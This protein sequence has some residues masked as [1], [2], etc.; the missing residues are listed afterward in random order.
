MLWT[1]LAVYFLRRERPLWSAAA[2]AA[3]ALTREQLVFVLPLLVLPWLARR[4][5]GAVALFLSVA[6]GP[7]VIWQAVLRVIFGHWGLE[8]SFATTRGLHLPLAG[9]WAQRSQP[10]FGDMIVFVAVPLICAGLVALAWIWQR[11]I[12]ALLADPVPLVVLI[13]AALTTMT[14]AHEWE[15]T[16]ASAR[17]VAPVAV[18]GVVVTCD[19]APWPRRSYAVLL[20]VTALATFVIPP[21]LF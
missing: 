14:A 5:W 7:F 18:L 4:Q 15:G 17:L 2:V 12:R 3:A 13:T 6:L 10:E 8:G 16:W 9:L 11:G 19:L 21:L 1:V 20:G